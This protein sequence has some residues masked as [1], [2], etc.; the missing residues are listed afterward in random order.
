MTQVPKGAMVG[1]S[2]H[3]KFL[4]YVKTGDAVS[5]GHNPHKAGL[6]PTNNTAQAIY[7]PQACVFVAKYNTTLPIHD[8]DADVEQSLAVRNRRAA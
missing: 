6:T 7:P 2:L 1:V 8:R 4:A 3:T 5:L